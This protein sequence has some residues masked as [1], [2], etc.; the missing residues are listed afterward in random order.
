MNKTINL[1]DKIYK[2][3]AFHLPKRIIW[4][5]IFR[6]W[7]YYLNLTGHNKLPSQVLVHELLTRLDEK[8]W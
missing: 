6:A 8:S 7:K 2:W 3:I 1:D 4:F 5:C